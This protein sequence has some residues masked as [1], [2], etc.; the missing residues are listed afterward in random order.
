MDFM[1]RTAYVEPT[2][3]LD[4]LFSGEDMIN[5]TTASC[6]NNEFKQ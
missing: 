3:D 1:S 4:N 2:R 5:N 6:L